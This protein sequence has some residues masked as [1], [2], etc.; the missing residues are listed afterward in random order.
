M[1]STMGTLYRSTSLCTTISSV[2]LGASRGFRMARRL[3]M[4]SATSARRS[5][6]L[7]WDEEA[8]TCFE[9]KPSN[10]DFFYFG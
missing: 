3:R 1:R 4:R 7:G 2:W 6:G 10:C 8:Q 9:S 5:S